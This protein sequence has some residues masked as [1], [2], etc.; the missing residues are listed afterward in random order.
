MK[1]NLKS[2]GESSALTIVWLRAKSDK[3]F[4]LSY[5]F[6]SSSSGRLKAQLPEPFH[7]AS[8]TTGRSSKFQQKLQVLRDRT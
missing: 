7:E 5:T 4:I 3:H 1:I 8:V 2:A 6:L